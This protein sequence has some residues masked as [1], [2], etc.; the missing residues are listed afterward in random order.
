MT[1]RRIATV[2]L[3]AYAAGGPVALFGLWRRSIDGVALFG[4][5]AVWIGVLLVLVALL[6]L[7]RRR[8]AGGSAA[9]GPAAAPEAPTSDTPTAEVP[10][11]GTRRSDTP[12][13]DAAGSEGG[14]VI[15]VDDPVA[16]LFRGAFPYHDASAELADGQP[17]PSVQVRRR[18]DATELEL[19]LQHRQDDEVRYD[20]ILVPER[21]AIDRALSAPR[22]RDHPMPTR[23]LRLGTS[24]VDR[25]DDQGVG[26]EPPTEEHD[27]G[28]GRIRLP[29]DALDVPAL[30]SALALA[31]KHRSVVVE[32]TFAGDHVSLSALLLHI[33]A[34]G[35]VVCCPPEL[36][37]RLALLSP[38]VRDLLAFDPDRLIGDDLAL[39]SRAARQ[40]RAAWCGH[41]LRLGWT[42][43]SGT[44]LDAWRPVLRPV[45]WP[46]VSIVLVSRRPHVVPS[47]LEMIAA[48]Q[49]V[50]LEVV[51][52]LHG[53]GE[54]AALD[55]TRDRFGLQGAVLSVPETVPF[56]AVLNH[57]ISHTSA[58]VVLKWDDDDLYGPHH[59]QDLLVARRQSGAPLVGKG[60]E[61]VHFDGDGTTVWRYPKRAEGPSVW[62]AG[63]TFLADRAMLD[64]VG[65][66]PDVRR[67]VDHHL[68]ERLRERGMM[69]FR[70]H[71]FGF[72]LRRHA[73]GHTW[74]ASDEQLR[75]K[76]IRT[77]DGLPEVLE[78]GDA[79]RFA[80]LPPA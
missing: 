33:V 7:A 72:A 78:L 46:S 30:G 34:S 40:K 73:D 13:S 16:S 19:V 44:T 32:P 63:G 8:R 48:Q 24:T 61:F 50:D 80:R 2:G 5:G 22:R 39:A 65:G 26:A 28:G 55:A 41:D 25:E 11:T 66:Y 57:A 51:T 53:G 42:A 12:T 23:V 20:E 36:A 62:L 18:P 37:E 74:P 67:A 9:A 71:G 59:V 35:I 31:R 52:V 77:F 43:G 27:E 4:L 58:S 21:L 6:Q 49:G 68:K 64:D 79:A 69:P 14:P 29:T 38:E 54:V 76:A 10:P 15:D 3:A 17:V 75:S 60:S 1:A 70:T 47:A 56:G 45:P